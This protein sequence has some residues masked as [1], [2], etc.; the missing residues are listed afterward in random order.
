MAQAAGAV[1]GIGASLFGMY[2]QKQAMEQQKK[3]MQE[4]RR[5][6]R[7]A[8][9]REQRQLLRQQ[10]IAAGQTVN[11]AAQI[12]GQGGTG[13]IGGL[14]GLQNQ[15]LSSLG[16]QQMSSRSVDRQQ[17]FL[18]KAAQYQTQAGIAQGV[19]SIGGELG[20]IGSGLYNTGM[21]TLGRMANPM[22]SSGF[23]MRYT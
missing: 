22:Q 2:S 21:Q 14:S 18:N 11:V 7:A 10:A 6:Q 5:L 12:G 19:A 3:A 8:D 15:V 4:Q 20:T 17:G 1:I 16:F 13:L 9:Q 23:G